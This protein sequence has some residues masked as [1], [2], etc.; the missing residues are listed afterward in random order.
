MNLCQ[1]CGR[2]S[3]EVVDDCDNPAYPYKV[4]K[5]CHERLVSRSLRPREYFNLTSQHGMTFLLHDDFYDNDGTACDPEVALVVDPGLTFPML[6]ELHDLQSIVDYAMVA[7]WLSDDVINA[8]GRFEKNAILK[9]LDKRINL[10]KG[11]SARIYQLVALTLGQYADEWIVNQWEART[12]DN[13]PMYAEALAKCLEPDMGFELYSKQLD[14]IEQPGKLAETM[15]GLIYFQSKR[16]LRW[17]EENVGR[18]SNISDAWGHIAVA[19]QFDWPTAEKWLKGGRPLSLVGLDALANCAVTPE[20]QNSTPWLKNNPQRLLAPEPMEKMNKIL[21]Q[22]SEND[23]VPRVGS[24]IN[25]I[26]AN[27]EKILKD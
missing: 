7:G 11:L 24:K 13:F 23:K 6:S 26:M 8:I 21:L 15:T 27:W 3:V 16:G 17:I 25:Y 22:H 19:S 2:N 18:V 5:D 12:A 4:C 1:S 20:T 10:N 9:E 14:R